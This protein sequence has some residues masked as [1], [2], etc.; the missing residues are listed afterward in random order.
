[1]DCHSLEP[2]PEAMQ[3]AGQQ[4]NVCVYFLGKCIAAKGKVL[5]AGADCDN[6]IIDLI[7]IH[8]GAVY[9]SRQLLQRATQSSNQ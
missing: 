6:D 3:C 9:A 4:C 1:M 5:Q 8:L 2:S 7:Y